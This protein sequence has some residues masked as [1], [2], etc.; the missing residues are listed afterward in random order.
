MA[1]DYSIH[2][3]TI[4]QGVWVSPDAGESWKAGRWQMISPTLTTLASIAT[5]ETVADMLEDVARERHLD[6]LTAE[7]RIQ[8]MMPLR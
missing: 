3:G 6:E 7:L 1:G 8:G 5:Y 2:I 4:G